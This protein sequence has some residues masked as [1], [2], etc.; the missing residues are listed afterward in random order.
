MV[1]TLDY[2]APEQIL[3]DPVDGRTDVYALGCLLYECLSGKAPFR[4]P[5]EAETFGRT[6]R[7]SRLRC[8]TTRARP[9]A[10]QGARQG[11]RGPLRDLWR[12]DRRGRGRARPGLAPRRPRGARRARRRHG[13]LLLAGGL[14]LAVVWRLGPCGPAAAE[15]ETRPRGNGVAAIGGADAEL[16]S[17]IDTADGSGQPR[18]GRGRRLGAEPRGAGRSSGSTLRPRRVAPVHAA[19]RPGR[20]RTGPGALGDAGEVGGV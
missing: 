12:A 11:P 6:S 2:L 7:R 9:G 5:T 20:R 15:T 14:L 18:G 4:R 13:R 3:G 10:P 1:G 16:A 19:R 17:F 8:G